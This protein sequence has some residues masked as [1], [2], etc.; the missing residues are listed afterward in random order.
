MIRWLL[1]VLIPVT[2]YAFNF[3]CEPL[4]PGEGQPK[5]VRHNSLINN[6]SLVYLRLGCPGGCSG[7]IVG[8]NLIL[9][10]AHCLAESPYVFVNYS[11]NSMA[12]GVVLKMG[13]WRGEMANDWALIQTDTG[14]RK[15]LSLACK[16]PETGK[17]Q[18]ITCGGKDRPK[19]QTMPVQF[20]GIR[21]EPETHTPYLAFKAPVD[22]GDSGSPVLDGEGHIVGVTSELDSKDPNLG[23]ACPLSSLIKAL[24]PST[25]PSCPVYPK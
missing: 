19:Q 10:S 25:A 9:T 15:A 6:E 16:S 23:K 5:K 1:L 2:A 18:D 13:N 7:A 11:D 17:G 20:L 3:H 12:L 14:S 21:Q 22:H 24:G 8:P 4:K